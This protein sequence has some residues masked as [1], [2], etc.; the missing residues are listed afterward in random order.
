MCVCVC[1]AHNRMPVRLI[2]NPTTS[3]QACVGSNIKIII[4][5][6][7]IT[8]GRFG[9]LTATA[10]TTVSVRHTHDIILLYL[11]R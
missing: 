8:R 7:R 10:R 1:V 11:Y 9:I 6:M 3:L 5:Y 4:I 2:G